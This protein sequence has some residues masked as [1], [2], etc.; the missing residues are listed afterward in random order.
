M[1]AVWPR[2]SLKSIASYGTKPFT[3]SYGLTHKS[4]SSSSWVCQQC[5]QNTLQLLRALHQQPG[6]LKGPRRDLRSRFTPRIY[7]VRHE[8]TSSSPTPTQHDV[9][10]PQTNRSDLPS[11]SEHRRSQTSKRFTHIMDSLQSRVF[12]A[13]QRINDL[14]GYSGIE[15]LKKDIEDQGLS[16]L[17]PSLP[18]FRK[19]KPS[20]P[21]LFHRNGGPRDS[22]DLTRRKGSLYD[23]HRP[24]LRLAA[25]SQ[26]TLTTK[27][28][29]VAS[30]PGA[31]HSPLSLGSHELTN[32]G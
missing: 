2:A 28:R 17:P 9:P 5:Q 16:S 7:S 29:M 1:K 13:G 26:R 31:L 8:S 30:G 23:I 21:N 27:T 25:R 10:P 15:A 24:A 12:I 14:T 6:V 18:T 20:T 3:R 22:Q 11:Q 4:L 19:K 32:R